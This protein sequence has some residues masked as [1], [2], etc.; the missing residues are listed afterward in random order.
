M[1]RF[2]HAVISSDT[3]DPRWIHDSCEELGGLE[4]DV[5]IEILAGKW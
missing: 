5:H 1:V 4:N 3:A 2:R